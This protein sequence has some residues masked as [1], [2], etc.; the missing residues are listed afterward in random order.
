MSE[1]FNRAKDG[2]D[3]KEYL[4][5]HHNIVF[6]RNFGD[7]CPFCEGGKGKFSVKSTPQGDFGYCFACDTGGDVVKIEELINGVTPIEAA[8]IVCRNRGIESDEPEN[9]ETRKKREE[10]ARIREAKRKNLELAERG[11]HKRLV[12]RLSKEADEFSQAF[13]SQKEGLKKEYIDPLFHNW[14][15]IIDEWSGVYLGWDKD[16]ETIVILNRDTKGACENIK[17]RTKKKFSGKW[18]SARGAKVSPFPLGFFLSRDDDR[19]VICE[20]EKD[21][22]NLL[23]IGVAALTL[24]GVTSK[25]AGEHLNLLKGKKA[26]IFFDHDVKHRDK[27]GNMLGGYPNALRRYEE[28]APVAKETYITLFFKINPE[29]ASG[30]DISDFLREKEITTAS[31]FWDTI[32]YHAFK[33]NNSLID[34]I[35]DY[36]AS[37]FDAFKTEEKTKTFDEIADELIKATEEVKGE[38]DTPKLDRLARTLQEAK[39]NEVINLAIETLSKQLA[40]VVAETKVSDAI[41]A[42]SSAFDF[43]VSQLDKFRQTHIADMVRELLRSSRATGYE[44]AKFRS[45]LHIWANTHYQPLKDYEI[46]DFIMQRWFVA[47]KVDYKKQLVRNANEVIDNLSANS[48]TLDTIRDESKNRVLTAQNGTIIIRPHGGVTFT[49]THNKKWGA[50]NLLP[51]NFDR[52]ATAPKWERFLR[53]VLPDS[54]DQKTLMEFIGYCF[55]P[56][57]NFETFLFLYGKSGANGKSTALSVIRE[58]FGDDNVSNLQLQQFAGHEMVSLHNKLLNIGAEIDPKGLNDGQISSLK[59]LVSSKDSLQI[60]PKNREPFSMLYTQKPKLIFSGNSKPKGGLDD[61]F[62]RR[63]LMLNF[64]EEIK[65]DEKVRDLTDRFKDELAGIFNLAIEGLKRLVKNGRFTRSQAMSAALEEY[66]DEV[67]QIRSYAKE[68]LVL[69]RATMVP[70]PWLYAH[71]KA[72]ADTA[73]YQVY[74]EKSF[75]SKLREEIKFADGVQRWDHALLPSRVRWCEG[76]YVKPVL[77]SFEIKKGDEIKTNDINISTSG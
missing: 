60:N 16:N 57:H 52:E 62:F 35:N 27:I 3:L 77:R 30:Y 6:R 17:W 37:D 9:D 36:L 13:A 45:L 21:A 7:N 75:F 25:W 54:D 33:L 11:E 76:L 38:L 14:S 20:G 49:K 71:Y 55:L 46:S 50:T 64:A 42:V 41:A 67:N 65:D 28:I 74:S 66:K 24:G 23:S 10:Q 44:F 73:G 59:L 18:I 34:E 63:M 26:Y 2:L 72:W 53:R 8:R 48:R 15:D 5:K 56:T 69:E 12:E 43:K 70:R 40:N 1:I 58:F 22:L 47:A 51:F 4:E 32:T 19:V 68:N 39:S 31:K 61:G 29:L